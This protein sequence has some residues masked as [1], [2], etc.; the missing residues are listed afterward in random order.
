MLFS[1]LVTVCYILIV[2]LLLYFRLPSQD[3]VVYV[4]QNK[5]IRQDLMLNHTFEVIFTIVVNETN[6]FYSIMSA[7]KCFLIGV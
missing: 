4:A 6:I 2:N 5:S 7:V 3:Q 1:R